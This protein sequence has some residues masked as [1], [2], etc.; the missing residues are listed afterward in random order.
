M[1]H[2]LFMSRVTSGDV[3][4]LLITTRKTGNHKVPSTFVRLQLQGSKHS[5]ALW[6][7]W[8]SF[9]LWLCS[10]TSFVLCVIP[11]RQMY[12]TVN[13]HR[14]VYSVSFVGHHTSPIRLIMDL[15]HTFAQVCLLL[16]SL[17][18]YDS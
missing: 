15:T 12:V 8:F 14:I 17:V 16:F 4:S 9:S 18:R 2:S 13:S 6:I 1:K 10:P 5:K 3:L 7:L 11:L